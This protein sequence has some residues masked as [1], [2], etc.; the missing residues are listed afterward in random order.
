MID[1]K[2]H[3]F[4]GFT[5]LTDLVKAVFIARVAVVFNVVTHQ[6]HI[7]FVPVR[8]TAAG[9]KIVVN[10]DDRGVGFSGSPAFEHLDRAKSLQPALPGIG[11]QPGAEHAAQTVLAFAFAHRLVKQV[12]ADFPDVLKDADVMVRYIAPELTHAELAPDH[13]GSTGAQRG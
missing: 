7:G 1:D 8:H 3:G 2:A 13:N 6:P 12:T 10:V 5:D 9:P 11:R 4:T